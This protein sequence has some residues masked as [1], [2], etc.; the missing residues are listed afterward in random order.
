MESQLSIGIELKDLL[1]A[2]RL[3]LHNLYSR[4]QSLHLAEQIK[5]QEHLHLVRICIKLHGTITD[6]IMYRSAIVNWRLPASSR[7]HSSSNSQQKPKLDCQE[8]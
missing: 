2:R 4:P 6:R 7:A 1:K 5:H 8:I 3:N